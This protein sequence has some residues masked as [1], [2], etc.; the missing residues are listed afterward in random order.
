M[1]IKNILKHKLNYIKSFDSLRGFAALFVLLLHGSYGFFIGGWV[2]VDLFFVLSG[3]LITTLIYGEYLNFSTVSLSKFYLRRAFRL[4]PPLILCVILANLL[5]PFSN[6]KGSNQGIATFASLFYF[7]NLIPANLPGNMAHLWSLAI[8]EH[9]YIIWPVF[10]LFILFKT[11]LRNKAIIIIL[12]I[13]VIE[14]FRVVAYNQTVYFF[15]TSLIIDPSRFSFC[16]M[17]GILIG[18]LMSFGLLSTSIKKIVVTERQAT[19]ILGSV[20]IVFLII[21]FKLDANSHFWNNGGFVF[22]NL[23]CALT[24]FIAIKVPQHYFF[25]YKLMGWLGK[26]SY[27]IYVYHFPIFL[28]MERFRHPHSIA[29]LLLITVIRFALSIVLAAILYKYVEQPILKLKRRYEP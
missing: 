22:T 20:L 26:R 23:L 21:L 14:I 10:T 13:V 1:E 27:G 7:V 16:R 25:S 19:L 24:V 15:N 9:F 29:N 2:G 8:E 3:Y 4:F 6:L 17:D 28:F 11:S 5:W 12:L 18:A